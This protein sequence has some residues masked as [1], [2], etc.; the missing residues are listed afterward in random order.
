MKRLYLFSGILAAILGLLIIIFPEFWFKLVVVVIGLGA[1]AYGIYGLAFTKSV[2]SDN[3]YRNTILIKS[4]VGI[5][6]GLLSVFFPLAIGGAAWNVM[7]WFLIIYFLL[8]A[9]AGFYAA[10][11][12]KNSGIERKRY[13]IENL[14]LLVL[15]VVMIL[16]TPEALR[17][18]LNQFIGIVML[19]AG[20]GLIVFDI[21]YSRNNVKADVVEVKDEVAEGVESKEE[22]ETD[23]E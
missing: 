4:I 21:I 5:V 13:I 6:A 12:L 7:I 23:S 3:Y 20:L 18:Y 8:S 11:L 16:F 15:A 9:A 14:L 1:I 22:S 10:A 2:S 17:K 19:I